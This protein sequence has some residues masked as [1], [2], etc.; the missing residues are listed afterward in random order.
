ME[1]R[2]F[3]GPNPED[4]FTSSVEKEDSKE[5][6]KSKR[7]KRFEKLLN[8]LLPK[9]SEEEGA[10]TE[11]SEE[12]SKAEKLIEASKNLFGRV[13]GIER[14]DIEEPEDD[15]KEYEDQEETQPNLMI[16][17]LFAEASPEDETPI[18]GAD[19]QEE[20]AELSVEGEPVAE[21]QEELVEPLEDEQLLA[22]QREV[23]SAYSG[24]PPDTLQAED[25]ERNFAENY[26]PVNR[27]TEHEI[28][29]R[30]DTGNED[31]ETSVIELKRG[32]GAAL[33]GFVAA[34]TLSRSRDRKIRKE[35][36]KLGKEVE[37]NKK[38][39]EA[40]NT[41]LEALQR[42]QRE[43][44]KS[45]KSK[46]KAEVKEKQPEVPTKHS[47]EVLSAYET[48][49]VVKQEVAQSTPEKPPKRQPERQEQS[50]EVKKPEVDISEKLHLEQIEKAAENDIPIESYYERRHE[51]KDVAS[52]PVSNVA[53][54]GVSSEP[55]DESYVTSQS[56]VISHDDTA[57][58]ASH[59]ANQMYKDA[60]KQGVTAGLAVIIAAAIILL[61]WSLL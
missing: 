42:R 30:A 39:Q 40:K 52:T 61:I 25:Q 57:K 16:G 6:K 46:R 36:K 31:K 19:N 53:G 17:G 29:D 1:E 7:K 28:I 48:P 59:H 32:A 24:E 58:Q 2:G 8:F 26:E 20:S 50:A 4:E 5:D 22:V 33:V 15:Y 9:K 27:A 60:V 54:V 51:A 43:E 11:G 18:T 37:A 41:E 56:T 44:L 12:P 14:E 55:V 38:E 47:K 3:P 35:A 34:E 10:E 45:L 13:L 23:E 49:R 21:E